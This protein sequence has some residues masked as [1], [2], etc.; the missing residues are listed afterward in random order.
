MVKT[1]TIK[2]LIEVAYRLLTS[3]SRKQRYPGYQCTV[4]K[5]QV[6]WLAL[7]ACRQVLVRK[8]AGYKEVI[9][10]LEGEIGELTK[11]GKKKMDTRVLV[12]VVREVGVSGV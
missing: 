7:V 12:K 9:R 4:A 5:N 8:Q 3:K 11:G 10:W 6:A 2:S 1:D